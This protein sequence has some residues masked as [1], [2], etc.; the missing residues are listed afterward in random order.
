MEE[1]SSPEPETS[2]E[3]LEETSSPEP[4]YAHSYRSAVEEV[5]EARQ[6]MEAEQERTDAIIAKAQRASVKASAAERVAIEAARNAPRGAEGCEYT[7][8]RD[9]TI[10]YLPSLGEEL[11]S[12]AAQFVGNPYVWGGESLTNG[13]DCSGFTMLVY[14][15]YGIELP[16]FAMSQATFGT[17]VEEEDLQPGDLVFFERGDYIYHVA[18]YIGNGTI[19]HAASSSSGICFS[20]LHYSTANLLFRRLLKQ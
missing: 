11:V 7:T 16:H 15:R 2:D 14:A 20:N 18:I 19:I 13:C 12:Y 5:L 1:T 6:A 3:P 10:Y 17:P 8:Q 4:E 9:H